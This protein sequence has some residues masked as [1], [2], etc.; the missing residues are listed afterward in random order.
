MPNK[1]KKMCICK[2]TAVDDIFSFYNPFL[3]R[4]KMPFTYDVCVATFRSSNIEIY[5][6]PHLNLLYLIW[7]RKAAF[8]IISHA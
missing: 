5:Y 6:I 8:S 4:P 3:P 2:G 1:M 7:D